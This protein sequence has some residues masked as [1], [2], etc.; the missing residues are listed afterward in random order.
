MDE[1]R[2]REYSAMLC[3]RDFFLKKSEWC[4][5]TQ[6]SSTC[7][8]YNLQKF[9]WHFSLCNF[10]NN[11]D[12]LQLVVKLQPAYL[13][14]GILSSKIYE[15]VESNE[16]LWLPVSWSKNGVKLVDAGWLILNSPPKCDFS[17]PHPSRN[18]FPARLHGDNGIY[19]AILICTLCKKRW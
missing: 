3:W 16:A 7:I 18:A 1:S 6:F 8:L 13:H 10:A 15:K 12:W 5:N 11:L 4:C 17:V 2:Q 19:N 9:S 14:D